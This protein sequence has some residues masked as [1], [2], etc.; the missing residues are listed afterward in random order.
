MNAWTHLK[1]QLTEFIADLH[2]QGWTDVE[3]MDKLSNREY[4]VTEAPFKTEVFNY[5]SARFTLHQLCNTVE[6]L[7]GSDT[8][9]LNELNGNIRALLNV[10]YEQDAAAVEGQR[11]L[12]WSLNRAIDKE[13][14]AA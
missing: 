3:I 10:G 9:F 5:E 14:G 12:V 2:S 13:S 6:L 8:T 1:P 4:W 7:N 11:E